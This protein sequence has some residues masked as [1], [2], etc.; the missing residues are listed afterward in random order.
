MI[1]FQLVNLNISA[2]ILLL[3]K[4]SFVWNLTSWNSTSFFFWGGRV[5][6][7][8]IWTKSKKLTFIVH[9]KWIIFYK[10]DGSSHCYGSSSPKEI[11]FENKSSHTYICEC[12]LCLCLDKYFLRLIHSRD[13][14][15]FLTDARSQ[16]SDLHKSKNF[17][18]WFSKQLGTLVCVCLP[19]RMS[20]M[21]HND[22]F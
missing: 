6:W 9:I 4:I 16:W 3:L 21:W 19:L 14:F 18:S 10:D 13:S 17:K 20:R 5:C 15:M 22:N 2:V 1:N 8:L 7:E 11:F 12:I